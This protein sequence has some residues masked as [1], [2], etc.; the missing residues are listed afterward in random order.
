MVVHQC[1]SYYVPVRVHVRA[2]ACVF[3]KP[4]NIGNILQGTGGFIMLSPTTY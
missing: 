1:V 3:I 2:P 4:G